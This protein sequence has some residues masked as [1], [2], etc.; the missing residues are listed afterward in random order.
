M[1]LNQ[2]LVAVLTASTAASYIRTFV[3]DQMQQ[4]LREAWVSTLQLRLHR[5]LVS[6]QASL[7]KAVSVFTS[8]TEATRSFFDGPSYVSRP[9]ND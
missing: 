2:H 3:A 8:R 6:D 5:S 7:G 1:S 9:D 4:S